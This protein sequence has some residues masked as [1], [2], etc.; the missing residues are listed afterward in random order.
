MGC[1]N[2]LKVMK[3]YSFIVRGLS[4]LLFA[5]VLTSCSS[6][7]MEDV[8]NVPSTDKNISP[9][10]LN[11]LP[12][13]KDMYRVGDK[14]D[15]Y[16]GPTPNSS[17]QIVS[18]EGIFDG[19]NGT[20]VNK[21][22]MYNASAIHDEVLFFNPNEN[23]IF[24][25]NVLAGNTISNGLCSPIKNAEVEDIVVTADLTPMGGAAYTAVIPNITWSSYQTT[26]QQWRSSPNA[27][28]SVTTE[29]KVQEI[30]NEKEFA[31]HLGINF[32]GSLVQ[33]GLSLDTQHNRKKTHVLVSFIQKLF[34]VST[35]PKNCILKSADINSFN[36]VMPVY[37]SSVHYGRM[38]FAL[39]STNYSYDEVT[40]ALNLVFPKLNNLS[41]DLQIKYK[42]ILDE[43]VITQTSIG[44]TMQDHQAIIS[45]GWEAFKKAIG[46]PIPMSAAA[47]IAYN[48]KYVGD[49]SVARILTSNSY[50]VT[51]SIFVPTCNSINFK[52]TPKAIRGK[53]INKNP[54][55]LYGECNVT[56]P[57]GDRFNILN[58][59]KEKAI[60]VDNN[61]Y[62]DITG[63]NMPETVSIQR[64][65]NMSMSNFLEQYVTITTSMHNT[66]INRVPVGDD[67]GTTTVTIKL[68]DLLFDAKAGGKAFSTRNPKQTLDFMGEVLF[69]LEYDTLK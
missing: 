25:G 35:S 46:N 36:G 55:F 1:I 48:L 66:I 43:S 12:L 13:G 40:A 67:L 5:N 62:T 65:L 8:T 20:M 15:L 52:F 29:Y 38:A 34:T 23:Q 4:V 32:N 11:S 18:N 33:A 21:T 41:A 59:S 47:P 60:Q 26:L 2:L 22:Q 27:E 39:I 50:P 57:N 19:I 7:I 28:P 14:V 24:P 17:P 30:K 61:S 63:S 9:Q 64:P 37:V 3:H 68:K 53:V 6:D 51:Q 42:S 10:L 45:G 31:T 69:G 16:N 44:G 49:N 58:I 56:L 54:L